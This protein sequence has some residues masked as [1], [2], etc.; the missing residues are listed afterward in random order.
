MPLLLLVVS[1]TCVIIPLHNI[2]YGFRSLSYPLQVLGH[3]AAAAHRAV[4]RGHRAVVAFCCSSLVVMLSSPL[5]L[6]VS[7]LRRGHADLLCIV[8]ILT[9][10]PQLFVILFH[11]CFPLG[12]DSLLSLLVAVSVSCLSLVV[13]R[14]VLL[15]KS[16]ISLL[17][18]ARTRAEREGPSGGHL[19]LR[20]N[21]VSTNGVAAEVVSFDRWGEKVRPCTF[22]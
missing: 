20:T 9:D 15:W 4:E 1:I 22:K 5:D 3:E 14:V 7:S 18:D 16:F 21:G 8:P 12:R 6:C 13:L 10:D 2:W 11:C 19:L 17:L